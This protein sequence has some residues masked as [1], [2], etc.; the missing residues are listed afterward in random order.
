MTRLKCLGSRCALLPILLLATSP[1]VV[2]QTYDPKTGIAELPG[3][4]VAPTS[5][6]QCDMLQQQWAQLSKAIE[7]AH[8]KCLDAHHAEAQDP[9]AS[10]A[11]SNPVCSHPSCQSLHTARIEIGQKA[12]DR[13]QSCRADVAQFQKKQQIAT[14]QF[15]AQQQRQQQQQEE[16]EEQAAAAKRALLGQMNQRAEQSAQLQQK[17]RD[18]SQKIANL[19]AEN[20]AALEEALLAKQQ[21]QAADSSVQSGF[22]EFSPV[23]PSDPDVVTEVN[24]DTAT[25]V[26]KMGN[27]PD[28]I[29][30]PWDAGQKSL[31]DGFFDR[32]VYIW[33]FSAPDN[34][35]CPSVPDGQGGTQRGALFQET[36]VAHFQ[37]INGIIV[38]SDIEKHRNFLRCLS[39]SQIG[40]YPKYRVF[41]FY[42]KTKSAAMGDRG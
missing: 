35:L 11:A 32:Q 26:V 41:P 19:L 7:D 27:P 18:A 36:A 38:H 22:N 12:D 10:Y 25:N 39:P 23:L 42:I 5:Y 20:A 29:T 16:N 14:E 21:S 2:G 3:S 15:Q 6:T 1:G 31:N 33:Q 4:P 9:R 40:S 24:L 30:S 8:Q 17:Q 28:T 37:V 34:D 13:V